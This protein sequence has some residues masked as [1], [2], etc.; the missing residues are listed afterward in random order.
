MHPIFSKISLPFV[1][2]PLTLEEVESIS[3]NKNMVPEPD[4]YYA[5]ALEEQ[6]HL[7]HKKVFRWVP[8]TPE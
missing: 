2:G 6:P 3:C 4:G 7:A 8:P 1:Y 5:G